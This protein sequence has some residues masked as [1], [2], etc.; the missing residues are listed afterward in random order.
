MKQVVEDSCVWYLLLQ[1][2]HYSLPTV[3]TIFLTCTTTTCHLPH[4]SMQQL[5]S[6]LWR[7]SL[8]QIS[9][10]LKEVSEDHNRWA[11]SQGGKYILIN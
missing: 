7:Y 10:T 9:L 8:A 4:R 6:S 1:A 11:G 2:A 3:S 5:V